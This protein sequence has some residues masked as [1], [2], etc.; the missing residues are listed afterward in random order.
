MYYPYFRGRQNELLCL[1]ELLEE[2]RLS[3]SITPVLEPVK[4]SSTFFTTL[5]KF[6]ENDREIIVIQNPVVGKFVKEYKKALKDAEGTEQD[7]KKGKLKKTLEEYKE[8]LKDEHIRKA[9]LVNARVI[10]NVLM[11]PEEE[12]KKIYLLNQNKGDDNFYIE[13][14]EQLLVAASFIPKDEDF[15][16]EVLGNA[17]IL[18]DCFQKAKRNV[19]YINEPDV[20]FSKNHLVFARRGYQGFSDYSIVGNEYEESGFAPLAIAIHIVYF[21][22]KNELRVHHFVSDSNENISD[23]ARKFEEA[24]EKLVQWEKIDQIK[25]TKGLMSL[26]NYYENG[27]FPGLGVIK[28]FSL[29]HHV[30]LMGKFLEDK[31]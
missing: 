15:K 8:I 10:D 6:I 5:K 24:M 17:I 3:E 29:M 22:A 31:E 4:F 27:R 19:D 13:H 30:E 2:N 14:G 11:L 9:Y 1:R 16:D 7:E 20:S 21:G 18:E 28:K 12:Q 25:Y 23:P 26:I